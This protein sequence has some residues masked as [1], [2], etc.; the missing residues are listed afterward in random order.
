[1]IRRVRPLSFVGPLGVTNTALVSIL[2]TMT[3]AQKNA[4]LLA[5]GGLVVA[6]LFPTAAELRTA[7]SAPIPWAPAPG[8]GFRIVPKFWVMSQ[9]LGATPFGAARQYLPEWAGLGGAPLTTNT[10]INVAG[11]YRRSFADINNGTQGGPIDNVGMDLSQQGGDTSAGS[12]TFRFDLVYGV[13]PV[14]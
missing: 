12:G 10:M 14:G 13:A 3:Q 7:T 6:T 2:G 4:W 1:M 5:G 11:T 9:R 8:V